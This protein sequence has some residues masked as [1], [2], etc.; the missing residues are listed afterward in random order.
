MILPIA[1]TLRTKNNINKKKD[2][3]LSASPIKISTLNK[4]VVQINFAS[5]AIGGEIFLREKMDENNPKY[6]IAV[7]RLMPLQAKKYDERTEFEKDYDRIIYTDGYD[8]LR[9]KAQSAALIDFDNFEKGKIT[10]TKTDDMVTT[11]MT[12]V[13]QVS[14]VARRICK[15]LGLNQEL[16]EAIAM[17]HDLGHTPFGHDGEHSLKRIATNQ[18]FEPFWHEKNSLRMVDDLLTLKG[19][20][21]RLKNLNLTYAVRDGIICHCGEVEQNGLKPRDVAI[22][23]ETIKKASQVQPYTWEGCVVKLADKI[24]YIGRD[25]EDAQRTAVLDE[26]QIAELNEIVKKY[27]PDFNGEVNNSFLINLFENDVIKNSNP[28]DGIRF[29]EPIFNLMKELKSF[30][31]KNI[32]LSPKQ[33]LPPEFYDEVL[34]SIFDYYSNMY[35]GVSTI[36][37]LL[38]NDDKYDDYFANW[39][40]KYSQNKRRNE[41]DRNKVIYNAENERDYKQAIIDYISGMT[42]T[43]AIK[44]YI[45]IRKKNENKP[46]D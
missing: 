44:S 32:Y 24:A 7:E 34:G 45:K 33:K 42:D 31:Y 15:R 19:E 16:A 38:E 10:A 25:I 6:N 39:L 5:R 29:S 22:D 23:L 14:N 9:L 30:N 4:D 12:H 28:T 2:I 37:K 46:P 43:F 8:R 17:G 40:I 11:R 3:K 35:E 41:N 18:G 20:N 26:G 21:G 1:V 27:A 13:L 36:D